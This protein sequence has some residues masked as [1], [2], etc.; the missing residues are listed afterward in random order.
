MTQFFVGTAGWSYLQWEKEFYPP[1]LRGD[2]KLAFYA[3][4]LNAVELNNSF[5]RAPTADQLTKWASKVPTSFR[6]AIKAPR[7]ITHIQRLQKTEGALSALLETLG[8]CKMGGPLFFQLPPVFPLDLE[9]L[10]DFITRLPPG[11]RYAMEFRDPR[12]HLKEV[13]DLLRRHK[14]AFCLFDTVEGKSP[15][16]QTTD[17]AYVRLRGR[18]GPKLDLFLRGWKNWLIANTVTAYVFFDNREEKNLAFGNAL[19]FAELAGTYTSE[20]KN[21]AKK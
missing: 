6:F 14:I 17:F 13:Y 16:L 2:G 10:A 21:K 15:R 12:W 9:R 4:R 5:Y 18:T 19:R 11:P 7:V 20:S 8:K 3:G 1:G